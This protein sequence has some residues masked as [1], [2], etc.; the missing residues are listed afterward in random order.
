MAK[1][2]TVNHDYSHEI[3]R[4][5]FFGGKAMTNLDSVLKGRNITLVTKIHIVK[6]MVFLVVTYRCE[7]WTMKKTECQRTNAFKLWCWRRPL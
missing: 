7:N 2:I 5:Q 3:K 6:A 4:L 1:K